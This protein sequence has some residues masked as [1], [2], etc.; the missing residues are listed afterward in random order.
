M[1]EDAKQQPAED[2][3]TDLVKRREERG[4]SALQELFGG[5][6]NAQSASDEEV[7]RFAA[8]LLDAAE[9]I[10]AALHDVGK[11]RAPKG[12]P[13]IQMFRY[14]EPS[15]G[16][17]VY[18]FPQFESVETF[19]SFGSEFVA[20]YGSEDLEL[21]RSFKTGEPVRFEY[22]VEFPSAPPQKTTAADPKV[23]SAAETDTAP[24]AAGAIPNRAAWRLIQTGILAS[25][26]I[27]VAAV[28]AAFIDFAVGAVGFY[29]GFAIFCAFDYV[30]SRR[31]RG[32]VILPPTISR[33]G[34]LTFLAL[35][36]TVILAAA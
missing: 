9:S 35:A 8:D 10:R 5:R 6:F 20:D 15:R 23:D 13:N 18:Y 7:A 1:A 16:K 33:A 21:V 22:P 31:N 32:R 24:S 29:L 2:E 26:A 27:L 25:L 11:P 19:G 3:V 12:R 28:F 17:G 14:A 34:T 30:A 36:I 4:Y